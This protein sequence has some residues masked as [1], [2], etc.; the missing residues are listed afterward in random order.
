MVL[1]LIGIILLYLCWEAVGPAYRHTLTWNFWL[2]VVMMG[3]VGVLIALF[4]GHWPEPP[5]GYYGP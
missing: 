5:E 3:L 4:T 1:T 2:V